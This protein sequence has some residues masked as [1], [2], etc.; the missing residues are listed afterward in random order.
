MAHDRLHFGRGERVPVPE[1]ENDRLC[2]R[3]RRRLTHG[4]GEVEDAV[5]EVPQ[6]DTLAQVLHALGRSASE[7]AGSGQFILAVADEC[8][9]VEE[10]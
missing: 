3:L 7:A 2:S 10:F 9:A 6:F 8:A 1:V 5:P 4:D